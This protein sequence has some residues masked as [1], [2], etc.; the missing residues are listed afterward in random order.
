VGFG[1]EGAAPVVTD[2]DVVRVE[3]GR[4]AEILVFVYQPTR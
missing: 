3:N 4:I 2:R 1:P